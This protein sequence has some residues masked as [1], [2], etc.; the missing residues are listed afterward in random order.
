LDVMRRVRGML[1]VIRPED[2]TFSAIAVYIGWAASTRDLLP[3]RPLPL[4]FWSLATFLVVAVLNILN[5]LGD[6]EI[7]RLIHEKRA[8]ASGRISLK[9]SERYMVV[10]LLGSMAFAIAASIVGG[11]PLTL[12]IYF[13]GLMIGLLYE[14]RL[15]RWGLAGNL[16]IAALI[17]FPFLLGGSTNEI[18]ALLLV[19]CAMAVVTGLAKEIINDVKDLEGD[20]GLRQTLP[21]WIGKNTSL[22]LASVLILLTIA[23]TAIPFLIVGFI[24]A[25]AI[26][27]A[28]VDFILISVII[29]SF[30]RPNLAHNIHSL[31]MIVSL[32]AFLMFAV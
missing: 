18:T 26:I 19:L 12:F 14:I 15:K 10:L 20:R 5:D 27:I 24:L 21:Q 22:A 6:L 8:I 25:Y 11:N 1:S 2:C 13:L 29:I 23:L 17:G 16:T 30:R 9:L 7:D 32:P 28:V 31:G 3:H 4:I